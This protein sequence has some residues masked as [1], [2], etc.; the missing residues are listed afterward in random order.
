[1]A[2]LEGL[3]LAWEF[4]AIMKWYFLLSYIL[5]ITKIVIYIVMF[6]EDTSVES[7]NIKVAQNNISL[8]KPKSLGFIQSDFLDTEPNYCS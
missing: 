4:Q 3:R 8:K 1:M 5:I 2:T 7:F 6:V